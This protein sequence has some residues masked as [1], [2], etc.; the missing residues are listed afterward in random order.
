MPHLALYPILLLSGVVAIAAILWAVAKDGPILRAV[1]VY[2]L[3]LFTAVWCAW[4][5]GLVDLQVA[6]L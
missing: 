6:P 5:L 4:M 2:L 1:G 3:A